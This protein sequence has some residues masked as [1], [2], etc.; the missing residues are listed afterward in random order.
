M[1][2]GVT[3]IGYGINK[4]DLLNNN[5]NAKASSIRSLASEKPNEDLIS[6]MMSL[7]DFMEREGYIAVPSSF[8]PKPGTIF[9]ALRRFSLR[10]NL[11]KQY[12]RSKKAFQIELFASMQKILR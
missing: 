4:D 5:Y 7:G 12:L 8:H 10:Q 11:L 2:D 3:Q 1:D 9:W 6:G